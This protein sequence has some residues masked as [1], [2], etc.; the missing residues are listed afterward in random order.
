MED[1]WE[2]DRVLR[3]VD[4]EVRQFWEEKGFMR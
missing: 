2:T 1:V 3:N 4:G